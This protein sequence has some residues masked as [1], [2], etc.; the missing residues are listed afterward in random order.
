[1][2][3]DEIVEQAGSS[4]ENHPKEKWWQKEIEDMTDEEAMKYG[5]KLA[6]D[7]YDQVG[8]EN[9]VKLLLSYEKGKLAPQSETKKHPLKKDFPN[10]AF[11]TTLWKKWV[12]KL[13][14]V[15]SNCG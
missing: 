12:S 9:G 8:G 6:K 10:I 13:C 3:N 15:F 2:S 7:I 4:S 11:T 1:M 14:I 5:E